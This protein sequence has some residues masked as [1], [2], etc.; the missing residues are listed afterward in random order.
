M[1]RISSGKATNITKTES[2]KAKIISTFSMSDF[3]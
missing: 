2:I 1:H 3:P